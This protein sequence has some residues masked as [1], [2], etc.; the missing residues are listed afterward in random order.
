MAAPAE[1]PLK[2]SVA[3][4]NYTEPIPAVIPSA[5]LEHTAELQHP[6]SGPVLTYLSRTE[7]TVQGFYGVGFVYL[8]LLGKKRT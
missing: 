7:L 4:L 1:G 3:F 6:F 2:G 5:L 8:E